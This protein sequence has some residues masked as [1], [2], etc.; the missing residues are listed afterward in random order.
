MK[1]W[2]GLKDATKQTTLFVCVD[3]SVLLVG[4]SPVAQFSLQDI[5]FLF[6]EV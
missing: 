2:R 1:R 6:F 5:V 4:G 3:L